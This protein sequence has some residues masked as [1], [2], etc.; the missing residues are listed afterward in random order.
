MNWTACIVC[1]RHRSFS[2]ASGSNPIQSHIQ[3]DQFVAEPLPFGSGKIILATDSNR[4]QLFIRF[5]RREGLHWSGRDG[6]LAEQSLL[7]LPL[8]GDKLFRSPESSFNIGRRTSPSGNVL[9]GK[10]WSNPLVAGRSIR[11]VDRIGSDPR[12]R[13]ICMRCERAVE[14]YAAERRLRSNGIRFTVTG[15]CGCLACLAP[16]ITC[17]AISI[18]ARRVGRPTDR[19]WQSVRPTDRHVAFACRV[20]ASS[21][22][23]LAGKTT[24]DKPLR[25]RRRT[26]GDLRCMT[27]C[28]WRDRSNNAIRRRRTCIEEWHLCVCVHWWITSLH[29]KRIRSRPAIGMVGLKHVGYS[30]SCFIASP[31]RVYDVQFYCVISSNLYYLWYRSSRWCAARATAAAAA[32]FGCG[33]AC[34]FA[35][36]YRYACHCSGG[37]KATLPMSYHVY[38]TDIRHRR[39][40]MCRIGRDYLI[41]II[42]VPTVKYN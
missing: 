24:F 13:P 17:R 1:Y 6:G 29:G 3:S 41:S 22:A 37:I 31:R 33:R 20:N 16:L 27:D 30:S 39:D 11:Y 7:A 10:N 23:R 9:I 36:N 42:V 8:H 15:G 25:R 40:R 19:G 32:S 26:F 34:V 14:L 21:V 18:H 5:D 4:S 28:V 35:K 38:C 12:R 2:R